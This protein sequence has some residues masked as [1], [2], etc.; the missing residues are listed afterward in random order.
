MGDAIAEAD[1]VERRG[2]LFADFAIA[3]ADLGDLERK[4]QLSGPAPVGIELASQFFVAAENGCDALLEQQATGVAW[5]TWIGRIIRPD[6]EVRWL[7][8]YRG[9]DGRVHNETWEDRKSVVRERV[10]SPV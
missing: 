6:G 1:F 5:D 9:P 4:L 7:L 8:R 3:H 2:G 10:S